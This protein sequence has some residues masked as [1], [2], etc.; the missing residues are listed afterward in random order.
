MDISEI[1]RIIICKIILE[2]NIFKNPD[3]SGF[4]YTKLRPFP[5]FYFLNLNLMKFKI[6]FA[7]LFSI[8]FYSQEKQSFYFDFN[9]SKFNATQLENVQNWI[10]ENPNAE[11]VRIE[12]FCDWVGNDNYNEKLS[13]KRI[14]TFLAKVIGRL[15]IS[16]NLEKVGFGKKFDH[17]QEQNLNR[18]IDVYFITNNFVEEINKVKIDSLVKSFKVGEKVNLKNIYFIGGT[19]KFV[20]K[21]RPTLFELLKT[22]RDFPSLK[23]E[24]HGHICCNY[25]EDERGLSKIRALAVYD[26]LVNNGINKKR[27]SYKSFGSS[28]PIHKIP[29]KNEDERNENRRVEILI[30]EK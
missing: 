27:L 5:L 15:F 6:L 14:E 25:G 3:S 23:I 26:F 2:I 30:L 9:Q 29:E 28:Q 13:N 8:V 24:I 21:S 11:I 10:K 18:R 12:G 20:P 1:Q 17:N 19:G 22:M 16:E 7:L 4:F